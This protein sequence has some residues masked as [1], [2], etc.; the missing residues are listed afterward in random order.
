MRRFFMRN[1]NLSPIR[2]ALALLFSVGGFALAA[3]KPAMAPEQQA[4]MQ[5]AQMLG[6]PG[7]NHG[8]LGPLTGNWTATARGWMKPG[9]KPMESQGMAVHS[10]VLGGRFLKQEYRGNWNGQ[11]FE[12]LGYTGYDNVRN[13]YQSTWMDNMMTGIIKVTGTFDPASK[14]LKQSGTFGCPMT[15]EK[16]MWQ[17]SEWKINDND[18]N[19]YTGYSKGPDGKE[20]K[21]MEIVYK[22]AK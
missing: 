8:A 12:G 17:R 6:T 4:A 1:Q 22:R 13:E 11:P 14:T 20:F 16:D 19:T 15:G 7:P 10:W 18:T 9:D 3:D 21:S 2:M 5:K